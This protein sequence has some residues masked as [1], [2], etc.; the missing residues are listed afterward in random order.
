MVSVATS[1]IIKNY[2]I[3]CSITDKLTLCQIYFMSTSSNLIDKKI[4]TTRT[5]FTIHIILFTNTTYDMDGYS[6]LV[7]NFVNFLLQIKGS[8]S[9]SFDA[10]L[11]RDECNNISFIM[12]GFQTFRYRRSLEGWWIYIRKRIMSYETWVEE[13]SL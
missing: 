1:N 10:T 2:L 7:K 3:T 9:A 11:I 5:R 6:K 12:E 13:C 4:P 8:N